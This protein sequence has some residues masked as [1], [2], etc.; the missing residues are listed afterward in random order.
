M[1]YIIISADGDSM[2]YFVLDEA[3]DHL[4]RYC[5][6]FCDTWLHT[7]PDAEPY[8]MGS[9]VSYDEKDFI[10]YLNTWVFPEQPSVF[11]EN[12]GQVKSCGYS[13]RN[14]SK[15]PCISFLTEG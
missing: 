3:A 7:N 4:E 2:V 8:R 11:I 14:Y 10:K 1:K 5:L 12:I 13:R 6:S 15:V 9:V